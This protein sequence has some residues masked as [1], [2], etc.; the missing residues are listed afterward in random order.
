L[1]LIKPF[2]SKSGLSAVL[3]LFFVGCISFTHKVSYTPTQNRTKV[4]DSR[5]GK[6]YIFPFEDK[7]ETPTS[8]KT[9]AALGAGLN[10]V[11]ETPLKNIVHQGIQQELQQAGLII[12]DNVEESSGYIK[13]ILNTF[14]TKVTPGQVY[15]NKAELDIGLYSSQT[16]QVIWKERVEAIS[17]GGSGENFFL[18]FFNYSIKKLI[19]RV[20]DNPDFQD[21]VNKLS[22]Q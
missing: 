4:Y 12:A 7:L 8:M 14:E 16:Q 15:S 18:R 1:S 6:I 13:G 2:F 5:I 3:I 17:K 21:A 11:S 22:K 10:H 20:V 19:H 9:I